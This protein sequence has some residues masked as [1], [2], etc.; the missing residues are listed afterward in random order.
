[1]QQSAAFVDGK[2]FF[3]PRFFTLE[4]GS[5]VHCL[6]PPGS[7]R[8]VQLA[9]AAVIAAMEGA[10]DLPKVRLPIGSVVSN[11]TLLSG[12]RRIAFAD[13]SDFRIADLR[14]ARG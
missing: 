5:A 13:A 14:N 8:I 1:M 6:Y 11:K 7:P 3:R 12:V 4:L 2:L 9:N 10:C